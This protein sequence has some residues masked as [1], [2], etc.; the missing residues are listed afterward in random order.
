MLKTEIFEFDR[1]GTLTLFC[2]IN[3]KELKRIK[4]MCINHARLKKIKKPAEW[5]KTYQ[6]I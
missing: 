5:D 3:C 4:K 1:R 6:L 2:R